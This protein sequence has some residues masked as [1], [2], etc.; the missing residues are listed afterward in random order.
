MNNLLDVRKIEEGKMSVRA[1]PV[2]LTNMI[3][4]TRR[5][6]IASTRPGVELLTDKRVPKG[7][8]WVLGDKHRIQ[9]VLTNMVSNAVK[10][11]LEGSITLTVS[12]KDDFVQ[13]ECIDTGPGIP[14]GEQAKLFERFVQRGG[15][16][17]TGLG[18]YIAKE[19]VNMMGGS[20]CFESDP[21]VKPGTTCRI[22][23][24]LELC[25]QAEDETK[26]PVELIRIEEP[27]DILIIDDIKM[28]RSMLQRRIEKAIAPNASIVM[29]ETGEEA[30]KICKE[31]PFD[32]VICDQYMEETG[33][34]LLGTDVIVAMRRN[35][36]NSFIIGCSGNDLHQKFFEAGADMVWGKPMPSNAAIIQQWREGLKERKCIVPVQTGSATRL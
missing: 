24:P 31:K 34:V 29:A 6:M 27:I 26:K 35:K 2:K 11:T 14:T 20:I 23:L 5:M 13:L 25:E 18:L 3:D 10:Y 7:R 21:T 16:P 12:W 28:N 33:G 32:I 17:G 4:E 1:H 22:L 36:S 8:N 15:A 30:L 9:Q 19:I